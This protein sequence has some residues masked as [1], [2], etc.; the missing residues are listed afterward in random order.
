MLA[1]R[2]VP[3]A[4][5]PIEALKVLL[6]CPDLASKRWIWEQY[7]HMVMADT[8]QRPGG[9]AAVV[10]IHGTEQGR[11]DDHRL[12]RRA[13]ASPIRTPAAARRWPRRGAT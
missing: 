7:D 5:D 10:R 2:D 12:S 1:S 11:G 4:S 13:I 9:D 6:G 3:A 8:V